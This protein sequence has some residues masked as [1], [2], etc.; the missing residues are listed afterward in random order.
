MAQLTAN[1]TT[2]HE[3]YR[4]STHKMKRQLIKAQLLGLSSYEAYCKI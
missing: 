1:I 3:A 4:L 2:I